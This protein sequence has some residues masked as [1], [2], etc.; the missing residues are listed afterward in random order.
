[1]ELSK[2]IHMYGVYHMAKVHGKSLLNS[3]HVRSESSVDG[4]ARRGVT[5]Y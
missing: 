1:M 3:L 2:F 5:Q 4:E